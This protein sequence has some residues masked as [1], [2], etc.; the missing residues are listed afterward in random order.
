MTDQ[1][2][3]TRRPD[4]A[5]DDLADLGSTLA[6]LR[7]AYGR[8]TS[9]LPDRW[10][11]DNPRTGQ[12]HVTALIVK[13]RHG[14]RIVL[15]WTSGNDLHHWNVIDGITI[16]ATRDQFA[17]DIVIDRIEDATDEVLND[18]T[19]AK[20][21]RLAERTFGQPGWRRCQCRTR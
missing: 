17:P 5:A 12:C 7:T 8:D 2:T 11:D 3:V 19:K 15:G 4:E 1:T 14:G 20:R 16:D 18:T 9:E 13:E 6:A 10:T 21:D